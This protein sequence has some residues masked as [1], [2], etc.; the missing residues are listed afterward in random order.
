MVHIDKKGKNMG[1]PSILHKINK[2]LMR[3][4]YIYLKEYIF[5]TKSL[6]T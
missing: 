3:Y 2:V 5:S 4:P 6:R 1:K